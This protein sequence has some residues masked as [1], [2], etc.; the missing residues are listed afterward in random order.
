MENNYI[1]RTHIRKSQA[2]RSTNNPWN[3]LNL[4]AGWSIGLITKIVGANSF[5]SFEEWENYYF[6]TAQK[7]QSLL[8]KAVP[9]SRQRLMDLRSVFTPTK[10]FKRGLTRYEVDINEAHGR[11]MEELTFIAKCLHEEVVKRGNPYG[12]TEEDCMNHVYIRVVDEAYIGIQR[13]VNTIKTL[14][15]HYPELVFSFTEADKDRHYAIDAE[16]FDQSGKL[17]CGLQIKSAFF[18]R[19]KTRAMKSAQSFNLKK[20]EQY[21]NRFGVPAYFVHSTVEGDIQNNETFERLDQFTHTKS[22]QTV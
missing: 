20:H 2:F 5:Q 17:L 1:K 15:K 22:L 11:T 6:E 16:V 8:K 10:P 3:D 13:E 19:G 7:R 18:N 9:A 21:A 12:L 4:N 14:A